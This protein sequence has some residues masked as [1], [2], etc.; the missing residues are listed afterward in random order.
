VAEYG[1]FLANTHVAFACDNE[2]DT[3]VINRHRT[4]DP[5][6]LMLLRSVCEVSAHHNFSFSVVHRPGVKNVLMDWASRPLLHQYR[7]DPTLVPLPAADLEV[8]A[9]RYPPLLHAKS[10][11]FINSRCAVIADATSNGYIQR[12]LLP[13]LVS[14]IYHFSYTIQVLI[15]LGLYLSQ[16]L[17]WLLTE[18]HTAAPFSQ[19]S[20]QRH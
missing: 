18:G 17:F 15:S 20:A 1:P 6:L 12:A 5:R 8:G 3:Y 19:I 13:S 7:A 2:A 10:F 14:V 11:V 16:I 9:L 4:R